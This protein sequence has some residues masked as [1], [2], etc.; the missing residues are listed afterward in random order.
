MSV[1]HDLFMHLPTSWAKFSEHTEMLELSFATHSGKEVTLRGT[2]HAYPDTR[3]VFI[4]THGGCS[5]SGLSLWEVAE[6]LT[7]AVLDGRIGT[8]VL[9]RAVELQWEIG[10]AAANRGERA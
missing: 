3:R 9:R 7:G 2:A 1:T 8:D 4:D 6:V 10:S 5:E